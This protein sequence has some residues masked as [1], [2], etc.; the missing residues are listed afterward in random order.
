MKKITYLF[1]LIGVSAFAQFP[2]PYCGPITFTNAV[3]PITLVNFAGINNS[4]SNVVAGATAHEDYTGVSGSVT[5]GA[6]YTVTLKGNTD[7]NYVNR[8]MVFVDWNQD[9]DFA[10]ENE[11][12]QIT[13][14]ITNSTGLD[15]IEATQSLAV[16]VTALGGTTRMRVKKIFAEV[17]YTNPCLGTAYGQVEDYTLNVTAS[18]DCAGTP[19]PGDTV[20]SD[21]SVCA[22]ISFDLSLQNNVA[23]AGITYQWQVST[24]GVDYSDIDGETNSTLTTS[25]NEAS[26][27]QCVVTCVPS[28]ST[29]ISTP[30]MVGLNPGNQCYCTPI[31]TDGT[32]DGDLISN[33]EIEGTTLSNNTGAVPGG[34]SYS[35]F[36]GQP[37]YTAE[38]QAGNSYNVNVTV[39]SFGGQNVAVWIDYNDNGLFEINERVGFTTTSID[40]DGSATFTITL[41]CNPPLG[42]HR[43]RVRD[44]WNTAGN[45]IDPCISYGW[46]ETEDYDV[47]IT[48]AVACPQPS[49]LTASD[50]TSSLAN[51]SWVIGCAE[52][53]WDVHVVETGG[54]LPSGEPSHPNSVS[55]LEVDG[56]SPDTAYEFYVR[57]NCEGDGYSLWSGPY[58]FTTLSIL[59]DCATVISPADGA[60]DVAV[61]TV[62][63]SWEPATTGGAATSYDMYYGLT[64]DDVTNFV[65]NFTDTTVDIDLDGYDTTFYWMIVPIN[66][67]GEA[68]GCSVW[69]FTTVPSPGFCLNGG[70]FPED[71]LTPDVCDG[72]TENAIVDNAWA[73][74]YA[75]ISVI[76]GQTYSFNSSVATDFIT[77]GS[78][79]GTTPISYGTTPLIWTSDVTGVVRFYIHL[80]DQCETENLDRTRSVICGETLSTVSFDNS[81]FKFYPNPVKDILTISYE[82]SISKVY[83]VNL[84]GQELISKSINANESQLDLST[85]SA[86][87]YLVRIT[88]EDNLEKTIKIVKQ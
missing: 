74:E 70:L 78:E 10:D 39:G 82:T 4:S 23:A 69:S 21:A 7:G 56:L 59:P 87:T 9:N 30:I 1:M 27:Y 22:G 43:M 75:N 36:F 88:T 15:A 50:I 65:G 80:N 52:T 25:Q 81:N 8:F 41:A 16:P 3:E 19:T 67:G 29:Q 35:Y 33:I 42:T 62:P 68:T 32:V 14:T 12:Y 34:S 85:L 57:A 5:A 84:L 11:A 17:D 53:S 64:P 31:Y 47:T 18:S 38:L 86:G 73:G 77:I 72:V 13:Q 6:S 66:S 49:N 28:A 71:T 51:L 76:S 20:S 46:G 40:G 37:N 60:T 61:G 55:P 48:A 54:G 63:F 83:V 2:A 79:D 26:Y 45:T 44:V 24:N 58:V